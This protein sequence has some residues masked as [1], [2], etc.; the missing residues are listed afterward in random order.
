MTDEPSTV[1]ATVREQKAKWQDDL[2]KDYLSVMAEIDRKLEELKELRT[3]RDAI[4]RE[5]RDLQP[6]RRGKRGG[7]DE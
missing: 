1:L 5:L 7:D 3:R 2:Q 6:R 4:A